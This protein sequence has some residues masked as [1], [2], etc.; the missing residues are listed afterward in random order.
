MIKK[1]G[2]IYYPTNGSTIFGIITL[3]ENEFTQEDVGT[4]FLDFMVGTICAIF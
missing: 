1:G 2:N 4:R 3:F